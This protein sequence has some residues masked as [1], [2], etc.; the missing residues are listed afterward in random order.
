[1]VHFYE[2][3]IV[4]TVDDLHFQVYANEHPKGRI[5]AKPKYIPTDKICC[6]S[7]QFRFIA[8][9]KMNRLNFW[10]DKKELAKY[11]EDFKKTYPQYI[12]QS[13]MHDTWFFVIPVDRIEKVYSPQKGLKELMGMPVK[14][15][16]S[17]LKNVYEFVNFIT[18][19]GVPPEKLGITYSTLVGTYF[20]NISDINIT[21]YGKNNFWKLMDFLKAAKHP[22]LRWKTDEEWLDYKRHRNR[23]SVFS[24][25]EFLMNMKRKRSEGFFDNH[26]FVLFGVEEPQ[27]IKN[28]WGHE[29]CTSLG[30]VKIRAIVTDNYNSVVRP[31]YF[32]VKDSEII[33][34][35]HKNKVIKVNKVVFYSRDYVMQAFPNERIEAAGLLQKVV[36]VGKGEN[37]PHH[38]IVIGYFDAYVSDR[39]G[40]E[41]IK[42]IKDD[43]NE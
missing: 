32:D 22:K 2:S 11:F 5:I 42:M 29:K 24:D 21:V 39:R 31:G 20:L 8:G 4:T 19:S 9:K 37:K 13:K 14:C 27:E 38:R 28:K 25:E 6:D 40:K 18:Q 15:L 36:P 3:S 12:H 23:A 43:Q 41:Y 16:D 26:L 35:V 34:G 30:F 17:H 33:E 1:M 7:L 10:I